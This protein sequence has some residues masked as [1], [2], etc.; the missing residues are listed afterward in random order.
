MSSA[1]CIMFCFVVLHHVRCIML[2][3]H[4]V[5]SCALPGTMAVVAP[6]FLH[7]AD[8]PTQERCML[9]ISVGRLTMKGALWCHV[10]R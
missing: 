6:F 4:V 7:V 9:P 2:L 8:A 1:S 10:A 3:H 5:A